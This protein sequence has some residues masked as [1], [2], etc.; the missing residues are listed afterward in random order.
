MTNADVV[1]ALA[2][3]HLDYLHG[4][5]AK[6]VGTEK[7]ELEG[8]IAEFEE[9]V[10][11]LRGGVPTADDPG[12]ALKRWLGPDTW[13]TGHPCDE[14]RFYAWVRALHAA[15]HS[16]VESELRTTATAKLDELQPGCSTIEDFERVLRERVHDAAVI[17]EYLRWAARRR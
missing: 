8:K 12:V 15:S 7:T 10:D 2:E 17:L 5:L 14:E 16:R 13:H 4:K 1:L 6:A 11:F 3:A 9:V